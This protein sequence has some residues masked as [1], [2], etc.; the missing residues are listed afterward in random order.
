MTHHVHHWRVT[1]L[2]RLSSPRSVHRADE[3]PLLLLL[4]P[5]IERGD[6]G[7]KARRLMKQTNMKNL[8]IKD[9]RLFYVL[10]NFCTEKT[11]EELQKKIRGQV[12]LH[13]GQFF[14]S[15]FLPSSSN[16]ISAPHLK[17]KKSVFVPI[18]G[19]VFIIFL[20]FLECTIH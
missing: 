17:K 19:F 14:S 11:S 6:K 8:H 9:E 4:S 10:A 16:V 13:F 15:V 18:S 3:P 5:R 1:A 20:T 7:D 12:V 2:C